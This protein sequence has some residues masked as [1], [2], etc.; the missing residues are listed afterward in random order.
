V[1]RL[2][3]ADRGEQAEPA[4]ARRD[5][6]R[7]IGGGKLRDVTRDAIGDNERAGLRR[8]VEWAADRGTDRR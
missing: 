1:H 2:K 8:I 7:A 3:A 5:E 4:A 6:Q